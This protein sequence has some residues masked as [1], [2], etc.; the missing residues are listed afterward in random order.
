MLIVNSI[1]SAT[2]DKILYIDY[3]PA[4]REVRKKIPVE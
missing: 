2:P 4:S 3:L 1:R